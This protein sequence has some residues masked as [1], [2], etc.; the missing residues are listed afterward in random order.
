MVGVNRIL[1]SVV[2]GGILLGLLIGAVGCATGHVTF[3]VDSPA[4]ADRCL[5]TSIEYVQPENR[6]P[7]G[8]QPEEPEL[9]A[10][11]SA[12]VDV[13]LPPETHA[14]L[15]RVLRVRDA[16][17]ARLRANEVPEVDKD[18]LQA[19]FLE[20]GRVLDKAAKAGSSGSCTCYE[21]S[22]NA[23]CSDFRSD[24]E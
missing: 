4:A 24:E 22:E 14:R 18:L 10:E 17:R 7:S 5:R 20:V 9:P 23:P 21:E 13:E 11:P 15:I 1:G 12:R 8:L 16:L 2:G 6:L 3:P 19:Y